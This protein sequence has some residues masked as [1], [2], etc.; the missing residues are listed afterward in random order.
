MTPTWLVHTAGE[1]DQFHY[2]EAEARYHAE[3]LAKR[4]PGATVNLFRIELVA[5]CKIH[6]APVEWEEK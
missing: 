5:T 4:A 6:S 3:V 2:H 1:K